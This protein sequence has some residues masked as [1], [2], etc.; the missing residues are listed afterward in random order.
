VAAERPE[1]V[2]AALRRDLRPELLGRIGRVVVFDPLTRPALHR[3]ADK[4]ID[5][6]RGRLAGRAITLTLTDDAYDLLVR[7]GVQAR[8]GARAL[9][10]AVERLLVQPLGRALLAGRFAD[11]TPIRVEAADSELVCIVANEPGGTAKTEL[12]TVCFKRPHSTGAE[13]T[14]HTSS[15]HQV[16]S[17]AGTGF[18]NVPTLSCMRAPNRIQYVR[19]PGTST[20]RHRATAAG[21]PAGHG[22]CLCGR[23]TR[24][25]ASS[26]TPNLAAHL[27]LDG[28][29]L[30]LSHRGP[31]CVTEFDLGA[32]TRVV[33]DHASGRTELLLIQVPSR[34]ST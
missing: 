7:H 13:S 18:S 16:V 5:R 33:V 15:V 22:S 20:W 9:E 12:R 4:L 11:G 30:Y 10:Q 14:T 17:V 29:R 2:M 34:P 3:I 28:D 23:R 27:E 32:A 8:S 25:C 24:R 6:V 31:D 19:K 1:Q 26:G 21:S